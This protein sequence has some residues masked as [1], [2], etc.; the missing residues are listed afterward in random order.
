MNTHEQRIREFAYQIWESEGRPAGHEYRHWEMAC[1]LAEA[2]NND[3]SEE[4]GTGHIL[5]VIAPEEPFNPDPAPE[6]DPAPPQP[7][8]PTPPAHPTVPSPPNV[9]VDP[10]SPTEPPPH[11]S[12]TPPSQ[13]I[14][15][16]ASK[17]TS[18]AT[19][20]ALNEDGVKPAEEKNQTKPR[21]ARSTRNQDS[22]GM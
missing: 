17:R 7:G 1:K 15:P 10:I 3:D 18:T 4:M 12:P 8:Q 22:I 19:R 11:I 6:I 13:P 2:P 21:K 5:S 20:S 14:Q 9:P 16:Y